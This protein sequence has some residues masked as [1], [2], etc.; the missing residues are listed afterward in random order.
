[1]VNATKS[2]Y[3]LTNTSLTDN[4]FDFVKEVNNL[5]GQTFMT[6]I[7][8]VSFIILFIAFRD[9]GTNDAILGAGFITSVIAVLF[10]ALNL[11]PRWVAIL[12][13]SS[14]ALFFTYRM[15]KG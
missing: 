3:D 9:K 12:I 4:I 1:M 2:V 15:I 5:T 6:G 14:Y 8:L 11:V 10:T 7:L 13:F